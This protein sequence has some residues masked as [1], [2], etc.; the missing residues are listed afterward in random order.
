[1]RATILITGCWTA[2]ALAACDAPIHRDRQADTASVAQTRVAAGPVDAMHMLD[3][4]ASINPTYVAA[5]GTCIPID[6]EGRSRL[7]YLMLPAESSYVRL[8]VIAPSHGP[9]DMIDLVRGVPDG[10]IW[11]ATLERSRRQATSRLFLS[12]N[13]KAPATD[14]WSDQD[15]RSQRFQEIGAVAIE[16]PCAQR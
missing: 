7:I 4:A 6:A 12:A 13:D 11:S 1:M 5:H 8:S 2:A 9:V 15:A 14:Q 16:A 3:L 10:R